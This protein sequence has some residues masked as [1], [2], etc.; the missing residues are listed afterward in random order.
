MVSHVIDTKMKFICNCFILFFLIRHMVFSYF[1]KVAIKQAYKS[2]IQLLRDSYL[3]HKIIFCTDSILQSTLPKVSNSTE[4][5][6]FDTW[7]K[8]KIVSLTMFYFDNEKMIW[9]WENNKQKI[10][11]NHV[12]SDLKKFKSYWRVC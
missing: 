12:V 4:R 5:L 6:G 8:K 3:P 11:N 10:I 7:N 2:Q 1:L 9:H